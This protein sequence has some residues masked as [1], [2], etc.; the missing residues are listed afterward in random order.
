MLVL[1][2]GTEILAY[3]HIQ[4]WPDQR[5]AIR[6]IATDEDKR[7]QNFGSSV[8]VLIEKLL[9]SFGIKSIHAESRQRSLRFYLK[10]D[11][12][13]IPFDDPENYEFDPN[14]VSVGNL[15]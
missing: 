6:I 4:F 5:S 7:N 2:Q 1:Y 15:L 3:A 9:K 12:T 13:N 8:L 11:D 14:N 10:N